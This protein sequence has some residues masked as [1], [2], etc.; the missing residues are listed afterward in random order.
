MVSLPVVVPSESGQS[1]PPGWGAVNTRNVVGRRDGAL[2][3]GTLRAPGVR[4]GQG[5]GWGYLEMYFFSF[6][7][8]PYI[9]PSF[10]LFCSNSQVKNSFH[11]PE[12]AA[13]ALR[14]AMGTGDR[15]GTVPLHP[16]SSCNSTDAWG[17]AR[18]SGQPRPR[19]H[20]PWQCFGSTHPPRAPFPPAPAVQ[21]FLG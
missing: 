9:F 3:D 11:E 8:V 15:P 7:S 16:S 19:W 21:H 13:A 6:H 2:R 17:P 4:A 5:G 10:N 18:G 12:P 14:P 20:L 1:C